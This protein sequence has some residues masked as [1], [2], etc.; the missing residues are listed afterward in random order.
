MSGF[1]TVS[2]NRRTGLWA[3]SVRVN[4]LVRGAGTIITS[5]APLVIRPAEIGIVRRLFVHSGDEVHT[6]QILAQLD[7]GTQVAQLEQYRAEMLNN[8][9]DIERLRAEIS[10]NHAISL[11]SMLP[12]DQGRMY[13]SAVAVA[14]AQQKSFEHKIDDLNGQLHS[15][16][17]QAGIA[18]DQLALEQRHLEKIN[19]LYGQ[20]YDSLVDVIK[21]RQALDSYKSSYDALLGSQ[22]SLRE[23]IQTTMSDSQVAQK[24]LTVESGRQ[25]SEDMDRRLI[26]SAQVKQAMVSVDRR[27]LRATVNGTVQGIAMD[28]GM[29]VNATQPFMDILPSH[30]PIEARVEVD[31]RDAALVKLDMPVV[32]KID[33]LPY[34]SFG[35]VSG[36]VDSIRAKD[37]LVVDQPNG[38]TDPSKFVVMIKIEPGVA[39]RSRL[40]RLLKPGMSVEAD[41]YVGKRTLMKYL[42]EPLRAHLAPAFS[43]PR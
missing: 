25:L 17:L 8:D 29:L 24:S 21:T 13:A 34:S 36:R 39:E 6:G 26:L 42:V 19:G 18:H 10:R 22:R 3:T 4:R 33:A 23:Q 32:L 12:G 7:D 41:L 5:V 40:A 31:D 15:N 14:Q 43:E 27:T 20:G 30:V 2:C 28:A 1:Y 38:S 16:V 9:L 37:L 35:T 11:S